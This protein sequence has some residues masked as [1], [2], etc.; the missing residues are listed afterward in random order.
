MRR[1]WAPSPSQFFFDALVAAVDVVDAIDDGFALGDQGGQYQR[2]GSAQIAG[3]HRRAA[4][5][6]FA[7][8]HCARSFDLDVAPP[9]APVPGR[10]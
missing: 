10:A 7:P 4:E 8:D 6:R 1:I 2:C 9:C 5:R 3:L